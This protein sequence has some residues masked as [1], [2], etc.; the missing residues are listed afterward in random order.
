[1]SLHPPEKP[2]EHID[3]EELSINTSIDTTNYPQVVEADH[4]SVTLNDGMTT[5]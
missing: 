5:I 3:T 2:R 1:M 4:Q